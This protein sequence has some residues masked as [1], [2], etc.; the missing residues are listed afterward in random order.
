MNEDRAS[1]F[2]DND[3]FTDKYLHHRSSFTQTAR[4]VK[5]TDPLSGESNTLPNVTAHLIHEYMWADSSQEFYKNLIEKVESPIGDVLAEQAAKAV[6][7][8]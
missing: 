6:D 8:F 4:S 2:R 5:M 7:K 1:V 3:D